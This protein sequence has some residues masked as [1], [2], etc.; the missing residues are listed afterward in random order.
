MAVEDPPEAASGTASAGGPSGGR[1]FGDY[2]LIEEIGRG[3]MGAVYKARQISLNRVVAIKMILAGGLASANSVR[4]FRAEAAA[5]ASLQHPN[6]VA[7]HEVGEFEGHQ[8]FSMGYVDGKSLA[9]WVREHPLPVRQ[10]A[11]WLKTIAEAI[12]YAHQHGILHRDLKPSNV[13]IDPFDQP[14]ITDFGLAK[15]FSGGD[16]TL[17]SKSRTDEASGDEIR[18][19][20]SVNSDLT[21]TGQAVGSPNFMP[22]EQA[23]GRSSAIGPASDVYSLGALLY[24]LITGRPPFQA[25]SVTLLLKQ[26]IEAEPVSPRLLN[27][28][29]PRDLETICL[30]CMEKDPVR[31][32]PSAQALAE[33]LGRFLAGEP[34]L[35]RPVG[36]WGKGLRWCRRQPVRAGLIGA[37]GMVFLLGLTGILWQWDR[38]E[39]QRANAQS[40][41]L[42]ARQYAYA[43]DMNLAQRALQ[44]HDLG[45]AIELL[46]N[47]RPKSQI[48]SDHPGSED[49]LRGWEWRYLWKLCQS[50][51]IFTLCQ[52]TNMIG[53]TALSPDGKWVAARQG[54]S[55][56]LW[57]LAA[58]REVAAWPTSGYRRALA[59]SPDGKY[60]AFV[61]SNRWFVSL[62]EVS[63]RSEVAQL[64]HADP[65]RAA[66]LAFSPDGKLAIHEETGAIQLW[67]IETRQIIATNMVPRFRSIARSGFGDDESRETLAFSRDGSVLAIGEFNSIQLWEWA[68][69]KQRTIPT[70][71]AGNGVTALAFSPDGKLLA[72]GY[73]YTDSQVRLWDLNT[74]ASAGELVGHKAWISALAFSPGGERLASAS[75]DQ[76]IR[77]WD[78]PKRKE[79]RTLKGHT[80]E[81]WS[82]FYSPDGN[83]LVSGSKD[84]SIRVWDSKRQPTTRPWMTLP[85][86]VWRL[87]LAFT[88]DS[89][90][91]FTV[92]DLLAP[93]SGTVKAWDPLT[94][95]ETH[96]Y[97]A[98]GAANCSVAVSTDGQ[99]LAVGDKQG[100]VRIW[101]LAHD[102]AVTH[103]NADTNTI[104]GLAFGLQNQRLLSTSFHY[105]NANNFSNAFAEWEVLSWRKIGPGATGI[106]GV[107]CYDVT[108]DHR[109]IAFGD[110]NGAASVWDMSTGHKLVFLQGS[111]PAVVRGVAFVSG[112]AMLAAGSQDGFIRLWDVAQR[113]ELATMRGQMSAV[114]YLSAS[115]DGKR[116]ASGGTR[117]SEAVRLWDV[118]TRK[119]L[120]TLEG[121]GSLF[122][123]TGFSPDG[124]ILVAVNDEMIVHLWR[125]PSWAEID[126]A[127]KEALQ[128]RQ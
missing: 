113:R 54:K 4:R 93:M 44:E 9:E 14:Q 108:A 116:L 18:G 5:A 97:P 127:E 120:L 21:L 38:A 17:G 66:C 90:T 57:D 52:Y 80:H 99:L 82:V 32:Y 60:L 13:L 100:M 88:P 42:L 112:G 114:H 85:E 47:Y 98:L 26:V 81:V 35:A 128:R 117:P 51:E 92:M 79:L 50:D 7:V 34:V 45:R 103:F 15:R 56:A 58:R 39:N 118:A 2:E 63:T 8:Y 75:G 84:G 6:I 61:Y 64:V 96:Q 109:W 122:G 10:A 74:L 25:E 83:R 126:A 105:L 49:D 1:F 62:W 77:L 36:A 104:V 69:S 71:V 73:G 86:P 40:S 78:L 20:A 12:H 70:P 115:P 76:T 101:D 124:N 123:Y 67:N 87:G 29:A 68:T 95:Q 37:L 43:A 27:P 119:D 3:G 72:A 48:S 55:I 22:P 106:P 41:E 33:E 19:L 110:V 121:Q 89:G 102:R 111:N 94:G 107:L 125:A 24:H 30:K 16:S 53:M 28:N 11:G 31:R 59:F 46:N 65:G 91:L 23:E